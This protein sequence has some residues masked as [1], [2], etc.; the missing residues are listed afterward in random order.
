MA[1]TTL[2]GQSLRS[3]NLGHPKLHASD[4]HHAHYLEK[5]LNYATHA[6]AIPRILSQ[7]RNYI[8]TSHPDLKKL[9]RVYIEALLAQENQQ[10]QLPSLS[11]S[12]SLNHQYPGNSAFGLHMLYQG[13]R[14]PNAIHPTVDSGGRHFQNEQPAQFPNAL[15][16]QMGGSSGSWDP[17]GGTNIK[18]KLVSSLLEE[19]KSNK[20]RSLELL[21][22]LNHVVEFRYVS[23]VMPFLY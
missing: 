19:L 20:G 12:G 11:K 17:A 4:M 3:S 9:E 16:S 6:A 18:G 8:S 7:G 2:N 14:M 23:S 15:K 22:V 1:N 10:C 5:P 13:N 21:D